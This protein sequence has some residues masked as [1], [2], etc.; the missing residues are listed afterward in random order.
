MTADPSARAP[1]R[2]R[3]R[4]VAAPNGG[5]PPAGVAAAA[6]ESTPAEVPGSTG[7]V[8]GA[9]AVDALELRLGALGRADADTVNVSLGAIG[10]VRSGSVDAR[11]S[12]IGGVLADRVRVDQGVAR[13]VL[14]RDV[15]LSQS[16]ARA[17][18]AGT[19]RVERA[20]GIGLLVARRVEG[21]VRVLLD[22]RGAAAFGVAFGFV[23]GLL[24]AAAGG[25]RGKAG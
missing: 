7:L 20:A 2:A 10:G 12:V 4:P 18:V 24:R 16:F 23:V 9:V 13:T 21:N 3:R 17:V 25:R 1:K 15:Q 22:W 11:Q 14:A 6:T 19:V 5:E 8:E